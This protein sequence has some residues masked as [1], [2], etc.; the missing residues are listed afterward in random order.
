[1]S[2]KDRQQLPSNE[3]FALDTRAFNPF[4]YGPANC[5]GKNL[6]LL[7]MRVVICFIVQKF[8]FEPKEG[9]RLESWEEGIEDLFVVKRPP[10]PV[11]LELRR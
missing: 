3:K 4:S 2:E 6:A 1:L 9:F 7:E 10:L 8:L 11:T 5:V